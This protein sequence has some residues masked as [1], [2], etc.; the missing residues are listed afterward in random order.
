MTMQSH[1][2][3]DLVSHDPKSDAVVLSMVED[4]DW[5]NKGE[6]LLDLQEKLNTYLAFVLDGKL[7]QQYPAMKGKKVRFRLHS[8]QAP[9]YR[10]RQFIQVVLKQDLTPR[11]IEW[12]E[13]L[14]SGS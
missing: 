13:S 12:Q 11:G 14:I 10:E 3:I 9:G 7:E 6:L 5:G 4:R 1:K 2:V 8:Q